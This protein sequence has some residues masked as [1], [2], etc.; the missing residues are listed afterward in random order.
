MTAKFA[1]VPKRHLSKRL[2]WEKRVGHIVIYIHN[3]LSDP[4]SSLKI[5]EILQTCRGNMLN[6]FLLDKAT[7]SVAKCMCIFQTLPECSISKRAS[8]SVSREVEVR[9][10]LSQ[11]CQRVC[12]LLHVCVRACACVCPFVLLCVH[13]CVLFCF[14]CVCFCALVWF[15]VCVC[16]FCGALVVVFVGLLRHI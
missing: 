4:V 1:S 7:P 8:R 9:V 12:V 11:F 13:A 14:L 5:K 15:C 6:A 10:M 3:S 2:R 16:S